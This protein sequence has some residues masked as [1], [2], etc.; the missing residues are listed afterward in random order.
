[1]RRC[2]PE[3]MQALD[4]PG[5]ELVLPLLRERLEAGWRPEALRD[6]LAADPLPERVRHLAGLVA[7]RVG[8]VPVDA[9][10]PPPRPRGSWRVPDPPSVPLRPEEVNPVV[11]RAEAARREAI[12]VGS[13]DAAR[14]RSWWLR[15]AIDE[16]S[17]G[18]ESLVGMDGSGARDV[19]QGQESLR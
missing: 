17:A 15:R 9:A 8:R 11:V 1:M 10:P 14:P 3:G 13:P 7:H 16:V 5:L 4:G 19:Q 18:E 6:V 12:R 2:L